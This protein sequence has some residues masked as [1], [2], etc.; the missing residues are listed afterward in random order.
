MQFDI[1]QDKF[2]AVKQELTHKMNEI[3]KI[4]SEEDGFF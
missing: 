4:T 3:L 1:L 2:D